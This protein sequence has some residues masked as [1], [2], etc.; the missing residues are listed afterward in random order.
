MVSHR[1]GLIFT[2]AAGAL[3]TPVLYDARAPLNYTT[4][5]ID[6]PKPPYVYVIRGN[7]AASKYVSFSS[8]PPPTPLWFK[9]SNSSIEQTVSIKIDN[10]SVFVPGNNPANS[11][12][13]FR[14]TEILAENNRTILQSGKTVF[15]FSI[16]PN[17][18]CPL[19]YKHEHQLVF[20]EPSDGT[21]VFSVRIGS[22][23]TVPTAPNLPTET[24]RNLR[25]MNH[26]LDVLY[27][28]PF[29]SQTWHNFAIQVDWDARTL[30]VFAS[31]GGEE[32]KQVSDM[33]S[34]NS[35]KPVPDGRGEFHF[36]IIKLPLANPSDT[37]EQQGDVV[38]RGIQEGNTEC[39]YYS[40]VFVESATGG[41]STK[42]C[43]VIPAL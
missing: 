31:K 10:S 9:K 30:G 2:W 11:Q 17:E 34:N 20:V 23:F 24:A 29:D 35:T 12:W 18:D 25:V 14:R 4:A 6:G 37:P 38:R 5:G 43:T 8:T 15:H 41:I 33:V 32:L 40:G 39:L 27:N 36:G 42:S 22:P 16:M 21:H 7:E 19:D 3:A 13:G 1:F 28:T 26:A